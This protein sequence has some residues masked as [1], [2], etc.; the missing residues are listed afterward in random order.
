[1][2]KTELAAGDSTFIELIFRTGQYQGKV[3]KTALT[4]IETDSILSE[5][6]FLKADVQSDADTAGPLAIQPKTVLLDDLE[7]GDL[8]GGVHIDV[9]MRNI[10]SETV[11][12][13]L[14]C[15]PTDLFAIDVPEEDLPPGGV[16]HITFT[17]DETIVDTVFYKSLTIQ[18]NDPDSTRYTIPVTRSLSWN[19]RAAS[20]E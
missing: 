7:P 10:S 15:G 18:L 16:G 20:G 4:M 8:A 2:G 6:L 14:I 11:R 5:R 1:V 12:A 3:V 13:R 9:A 19:R 17:L